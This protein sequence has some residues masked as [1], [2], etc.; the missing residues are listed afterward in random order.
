M[1]FV[2]LP[3]SIHKDRELTAV[4]QTAPRIKKKSQFNPARGERRAD[5]FG[6]SLLEAS[7]ITTVKDA[8]CYRNG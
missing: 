8:P 6:E 3:S 5:D 2:V 1:A 7:D 4:T